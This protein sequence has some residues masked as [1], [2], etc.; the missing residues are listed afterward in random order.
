MTVNRRR[1]LYSLQFRFYLNFNVSSSKISF[2]KSFECYLPPRYRTIWLISIN[3]EKVRFYSGL[4]RTVDISRTIYRTMKVN[5]ADR[6]EFTLFDPTLIVRIFW[7]CLTAPFSIRQSSRRIA[8]N[9]RTNIESSRLDIWFS[10]S[11]STFCQIIYY[12]SVQRGHPL[13]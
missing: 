5:H 10:I 7:T 11:K 9:A 8:L 2:R 12:L 6:T 13:S 4:F 3:V 1:E